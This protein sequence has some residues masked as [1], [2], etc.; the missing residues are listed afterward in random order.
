MFCPQ[1]G[2]ELPDDSQFCRKCGRSLA[3]T[4]TRAPVP[5]VKRSRWRLWALLAVLAIV[6]IWWWGLAHRRTVS[7]SSYPSVL[8]TVMPVRHT[9]TIMNTAITVRA[10]SYSYYQFAVPA[11]ATAVAVDGHF[12]A[13]GGSGNDI[14]VYILNH[15]EFV[16]F[17]NG[18]STPTYYNSGKVTD[19]AINAALPGGGTFFLVFNNNFSFITPKA[20]QAQATLYYTD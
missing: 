12:N 19:G 10:L 8:S 9:Q 16:N 5:H 15:D 17:Q 6:V 7:E 14:E 4:T 18:H 3:A 11:G 2:T 20:V 1:C 13:T